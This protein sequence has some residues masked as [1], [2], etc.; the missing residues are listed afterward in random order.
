M[1][2]DVGHGRACLCPECTSARLAVEGST[3]RIVARPDNPFAPQHDHVMTI[4][5]ATAATPRRKANQAM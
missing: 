2:P 3:R 5:V 1:T 4:A